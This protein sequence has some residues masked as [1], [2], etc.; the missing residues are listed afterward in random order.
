M[1]PRKALRNDRRWENPTV[2]PLLCLTEGPL[3]CRQAGSHELTY[4]TSPGR[5]ELAAF[6]HQY[7]VWHGCQQGP[8]DTD[9]RAL[10]D[11]GA[12]CA[13]VRVPLDYAHPDKRTIT[14]AI[15]RLAATDP[16]HRIGPLII[17]TGG[18][19]SP[20]LVDVILARPAMGDTGRRFDLI[21]MDQRFSGRSTPLDCGWPVGWLPRSA[22]TDRQSFD[23]ATAVARDLA[24]RCAHE[25]DVLPYASTAD[26][27]RDMDVIRAALGAPICRTSVT[28]T[29]HLPQ[30]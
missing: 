1:S 13:E 24:G 9:G 25:R 15:S 10:D 16:A 20:N 3:R 21:G 12:Q 23:Q 18:P 17:N 26:A 8:R 19:A 4:T 2:E 14:V 22:G 30:T 28:R 7:I 6:E 27:A 29:G 11:G 5:N